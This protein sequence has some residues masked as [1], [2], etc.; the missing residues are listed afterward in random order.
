[1]GM[2]VT[3]NAAKGFRAR[4]A[5]VEKSL[6]QLLRRA[7]RLC[8]VSLATSTQP[9]GID[10]EAQL[11]GQRAVVRDI[12]K[13]Y[14]LPSDAFPAFPNPKAGAAFWQA[15]SAADWPRASGILR[16][17]CPKFANV[18][19]RAFDGGAAHKANR[20]NQGRIAKSQDYVFVV[21]N[22]AELKA[23]INTE[24]KLVGYAKAGWAACARALGGVSGL[25]GWITRHKAPGKVEERFGNGVAE[26][27]LVNQVR[28]ATEVLSESQKKV[29]VGIAGDRLFKALQIEERKAAEAAGF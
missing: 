21:Q 7:G 4:A 25:P 17:D 6:P 29:A 19:L 23:Y 10:S 28:Y 26:I 2:T 1:M 12:R 20:N 16:R 22:P 9:Y 5:A 15:V 27:V 11:L 8:A 18:E 3:N 24:F 13:V 14:A